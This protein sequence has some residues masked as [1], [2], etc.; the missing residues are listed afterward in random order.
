MGWAQNRAS[1]AAHHLHGPFFNGP[2]ESNQTD[3]VTKEM[4][5]GSSNVR[6]G[7]TWK[8]CP[9]PGVV[10]VAGLDQSQTSHLQEIVIF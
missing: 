9:P 3:S 5:N 1:G 7:E 8:S 6:L 10:A 2:W 4:K